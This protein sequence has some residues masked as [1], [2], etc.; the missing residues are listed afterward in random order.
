MCKNPQGSYITK[1]EMIATKSDRHIHDLKI[2]AN[3]TSVEQQFM[4][5]LSQQTSLFSTVCIHCRPLNQV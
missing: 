3:T 1:L 4:R 5:A 2:N